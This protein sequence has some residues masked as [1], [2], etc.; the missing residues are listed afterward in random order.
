MNWTEIDGD[1]LEALIEREDW[2]QR[3]RRVTFWVAVAVLNA[4]AAGVIA[5]PHLPAWV[6]P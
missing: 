3:R 2:I 1:E 5:G 4:F 6:R